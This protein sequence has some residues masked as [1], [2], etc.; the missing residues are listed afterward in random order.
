MNYLNNMNVGDIV[1]FASGSIGYV[2]AIDYEGRFFECT[3]VR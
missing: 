1:I 3:M 2:H